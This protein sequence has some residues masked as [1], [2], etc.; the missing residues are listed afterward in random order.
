MSAS[1]LPAGASFDPVTTFLSWTPG[2]TQAGTYHITFTATDDGNGTAS[3][4]PRPPR[5]TW[6]F[7]TK[8]ARPVIAAIPNQS[9]HRG[10]TLDVPVHVTDADG[11][12]IFAPG[13]ER[14]PRLPVAA[15][16]TFTDNGNGSGVFHFAPGI[17]DRG[18]HILM[19]TATDNGDGDGVLGK[20]NIV[21][22]TFILTV[23]SENEPPVLDCVSNKVAVGGQPPYCRS[24][25]TTTIRKPCI[26][27]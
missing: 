9:V 21:G 19:L 26:T 24:M 16:I 14:Q 3:P 1:N 25:R 10:N 8:T 22:Y 20:T 18:D 23:V 17:G 13:L 7:S 11:D 12:P 15:F 6:S 5:W 27:P 4:C 2:Y